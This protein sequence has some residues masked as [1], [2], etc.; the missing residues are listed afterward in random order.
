MFWINYSRKYVKRFWFDFFI[1]PRWVTSKN[2]WFL[3][4]LLSYD[5]ENLKSNFVQ[6]Y[7][8]RGPPKTVRPKAAVTTTS[9]ATASVLVNDWSCLGQH[10]LRHAVHRR[11]TWRRFATRGVFTNYCPGRAAARAVGVETTG[12]TMSK[13]TDAGRPPVLDRSALPDVGGGVYVCRLVAVAAER[14]GHIPRPTTTITA[15]AAA[16]AT[17]APPPP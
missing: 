17:A 4:K 15:N 12:G 16:T 8:Q 14:W 2:R 9:R 1:R 6:Y 3:M 7:I 5:V 13:E 11:R 10:G